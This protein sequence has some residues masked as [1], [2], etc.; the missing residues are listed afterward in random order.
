MTTSESLKAAKAVLLDR[1]W[2]Q[3]DFVNDVTGEVCIVGAMNI[4]EDGTPRCDDDALYAESVASQIL[5]CLVFLDRCDDIG[6]WNDMHGRTP[7]EVLALFD[8]AIAIA[9]SKERT[10]LP[11]AVPAVAGQVG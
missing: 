2:F 7:E 5:H 4:V 9:E 11:V 10:E 6:E 8:R 1:G 3:G